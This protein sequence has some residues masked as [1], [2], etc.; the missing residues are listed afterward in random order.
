MYNGAGLILLKTKYT[1]DNFIQQWLK[2][3]NCSYYLQQ[4]F[5]LTNSINTWVTKEAYAIL[6]AMK[7]VEE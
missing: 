2:H 4:R 1:K 6:S 3:P 5:L 7:N